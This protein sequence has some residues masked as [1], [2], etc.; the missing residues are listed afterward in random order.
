MDGSPS[1]TPNGGTPELASALAEL[2]NLMLA[3]PDLERLLDDLARLAAGVMGPPAS[4]GITL[5]PEREPV[6][7]AASGPLA[8]LVDEAQY[9]E[10]EGPCLQS[11]ATGEVV[12]VPDMDVE[13]R[14]GDYPSLARRHGV[15][16]SYSVPL[17]VDGQRQGALNLYATESDGFGLLERERAE[18]FARQAA[19]ALTIVTRRAKQTELTDQLRAAL[20]SRSVID[21]AMGVLMARNR[22]GPEEAFGRLR[23][24]SQRQNRKLRD[25]A[26]EV[27]EAVAGQ[28]LPPTPFSD[29]S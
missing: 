6:T 25:I 17:I 3:T 5:R 21:Q 19:A 1:A 18:A 14:W 22:C 15:R 16:S 12:D 29:P 7:V 10:G 26:T 27:V 11:M 4:C 24:A 8:S 28:R 2:V 23:S 20:A 9:S 13:R